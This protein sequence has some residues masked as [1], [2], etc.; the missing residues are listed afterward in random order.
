MKVSRWIAVSVAIGLV[1]YIVERRVLGSQPNRSIVTDVWQ[2]SV[3]GAVLGFISA[4]I[5]A[6]V[7]AVKVN[8]WTTMFGCGLTGNSM[9]FRV[10]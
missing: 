1:Y 8:G 3:V 7:W 5:L 10:A 6:R 4:Q 9:L 2:G